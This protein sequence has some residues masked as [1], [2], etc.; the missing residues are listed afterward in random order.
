MDLAMESDLL[1]KKLGYPSVLNAAQRVSSSA[2][3]KHGLENLRAL[4]NSP[5]S[6]PLLRLDA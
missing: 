5:L 4:R 6:T 2:W 1:I 3:K